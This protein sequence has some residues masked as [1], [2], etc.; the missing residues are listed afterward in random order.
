MLSSV[1]AV[2]ASGILTYTSDNGIY[3]IIGGSSGQLN[4]ARL[5]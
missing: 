2:S 3:E 4:L 5:E 1:M